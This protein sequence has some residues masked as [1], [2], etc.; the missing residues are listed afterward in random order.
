MKSSVLWRATRLLFAD[1]RTS[2]S[3]SEVEGSRVVCGLDGDC[4]R[5]IGRGWEDR[6]GVGRGAIK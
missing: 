5:L 6:S 3:E 4:K 2:L 1:G